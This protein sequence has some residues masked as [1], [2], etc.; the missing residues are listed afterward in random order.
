MDISEVSEVYIDA[1]CMVNYASYYIYGLWKLLGKSKC[2][3][4]YR[5]FNSLE[6]NNYE[7]MRKGCAIIVIANSQIRKKIYID[8]ND[9]ATINKKHLYWSDIYAKINVPELSEDDDVFSIGPSFGIRLWDWPCSVYNSIN[10]YLKS[11]PYLPKSISLRMFMSH[12]LYLNIRRE[13]ISEY[14]GANSDDDYCFS[15]ATLWYDKNTD[16]TTNIYRGWFIEEASK[17]YDNFE[18]GFFYI[19]GK[20]VEDEFPEYTKYREQYKDFLITKRISMAEYMK[21]IKKSA[22]VFNTP[23][24][25]GCHGWKLGEYLAMGKAIISTKLSNKMPGD[26][27]V[28]VNYIEANTKEEIREAILLLKNSP[29]KRKEMERANKDYYNKYLAPEVVVKRIIEAL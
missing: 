25:G 1:R 5:Q 7:D 22:I 20:G 23:S 24:V 29:Q 16:V 9:Q 10:N 14:Y 21:K 6:I 18:G 8:T 11:E 17:I 15:L 3:F 28:G 12:Y 26:F 13:R 19:P 4:N 2:H 27:A